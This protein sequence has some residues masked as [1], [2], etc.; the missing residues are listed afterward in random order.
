ML[1]LFIVMFLFSIKL[2]N[3][4]IKVTNEDLIHDT[5]F[6]LQNESFKNSLKYGSKYLP[7]HLYDFNRITSK[8]RT[9]EIV[10]SG[11]TSLNQVLPVG[12]QNPVVDPKFLLTAIVQLTDCATHEGY[13]DPDL[14]TFNLDPEIYCTPLTLRFIPFITCCAPE[15][16]EQ[17]SIRLLL[18][19]PNTPSSQS[20]FGLPSSYDRPVYGRPGNVDFNQGTELNWRSKRRPQLIPPKGKIVYLIHGLAENVTDSVWLRPVALAW[21][22]RG[23]AVI[24][25]DWKFGARAYPPQ[26][27]VNV[28]TV[29][30]VVGYS[31][32]TWKVTKNL[33]D[34]RMTCVKLLDC[35][36]NI[37]CWTQFWWPCHCRS[38]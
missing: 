13:S 2:M 21:N 3:G 11:E 26:V 1:T 33:V 16:P 8:S 38:G 14:G 25:V 9:N 5:F 27:A 28:R 19:L 17:I 7:R 4:T 35:P 34:C 10:S 29:G 23:A 24:I 32:V 20:D 36:S 12:L 15:T 6:F 31:I 22:A 18:F 30:A 37:G